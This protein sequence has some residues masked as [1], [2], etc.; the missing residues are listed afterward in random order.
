[1]NSSIEKSEIGLLVDGFFLTKRPCP[2]CGEKMREID[3]VNE[4]S[5]VFVWYE[6]TNPVCDGQWLQKFTRITE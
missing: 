4:N 5:F 1:M 6:C 2:Q 3:R